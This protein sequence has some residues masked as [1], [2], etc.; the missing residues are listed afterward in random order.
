MRYHCCTTRSTCVIAAACLALAACGSSLGECEPA[1]AEEVVYGRAGLVATK[2]QALLHDS[3]GNAA[4][5]HSQ[6]ATG[7]ARY[8]APLGMDFDMLPSPRGWSA[9]H[10]LREAIWDVVESGQMPPPGVGERV[11]G[12]GDFRF[13]LIRGEGDAALPELST[14]AGKAALRNWLACD[15]PVVTDTRVPEWA[16][17]RQ[18]AGAG[19]ELV[20]FGDLYDAVLEPSCAIAGCHDRSAAGG[21]AMRD[22]CSAYEA[23]LDSGTCGLPRLVPGDG[24]SVLVDKLESSEPS[25][26]SLQMPPPPFQPLSA[27]LIERIRA[28]IESGAPAEQCR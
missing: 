25:C 8:G 11:Q 20:D 10:A 18:D 28:W 7:G 15:A 23:L 26:G 27:A 5:C 2:G 4:F 9:V 24:A 14:R 3:C 13:T 12:D 19:T 21:L 6:A 1:L 16:V 17:P 22:A